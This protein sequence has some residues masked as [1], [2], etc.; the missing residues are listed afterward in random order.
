MKPELTVWDRELERLL[1][2]NPNFA[3]LSRRT[4]FYMMK[5][6]FNIGVVIPFY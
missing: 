4:I 3:C 5:N 1:L 6:F 2:F